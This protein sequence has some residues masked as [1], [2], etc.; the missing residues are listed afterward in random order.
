MPYAKSFFFAIIISDLRETCI[1]TVW[2]MFC[3]EK[4][5]VPP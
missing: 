1:E 3:V 5:V 4:Q 2:K